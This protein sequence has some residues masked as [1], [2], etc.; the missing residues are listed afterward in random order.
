MNNTEVAELETAN[1]THRAAL[2][3]LKEECAAV[4]RE[5]SDLLQRVSQM[6]TKVGANLEA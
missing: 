6:T 1:T 5:K 2:A 3:A 4:L